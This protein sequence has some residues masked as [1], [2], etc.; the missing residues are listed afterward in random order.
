MID[1]EQQS[2]E[3]VHEVEGQVFVEMFSVL[4]HSMGY[5]CLHLSM[6]F[7]WEGQSLSLVM[8]VMVR[9]SSIEER[10]LFLRRPNRQQRLISEEFLVV[11]YSS[12]CRVFEGSM[13]ARREST[14]NVT[15]QLPQE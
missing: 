14:R 4:H 9:I 1:H 6:M 13:S 8:M 15:M 11:R 2:M 10:Q 12:E 3:I 7:D 5:L